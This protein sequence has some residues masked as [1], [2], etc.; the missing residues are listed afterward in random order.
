MA[1]GVLQPHENQEL[2][3]VGDFYIK[4]LVSRSFFQDVDLD[5]IFYYTFKMHDLLHDLALSISKDECSV[6]TKQS[7]VAA[8]VSHLS[9]SDNGKEVTTQ[10]EKL[11]K[12]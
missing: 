12:V 8:K 10:L 6:V 5:N 4:E 1:H 3:D 9:F 2:E 11:S 7:S